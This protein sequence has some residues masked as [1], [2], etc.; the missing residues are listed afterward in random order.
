[1]EDLTSA[2]SQTCG[3]DLA[4]QR[5]SDAQLLSRFADGD[6]RAARTLTDRLGPR[7]YSVAMRILGNRAEAEDVTQE[8]MMRLWQIAPDW[9]A[10]QAQVSTWLYRVTLNLC[11]DLRR[12]RRPT[13]LE[14]APEPEDG[15][16]SVAEQM[17]DMARRDALQQALDQLPERQRQAVVL[18]HIEELSNPEIAEIMDISVEAVESLTARGKRSLTAILAGRKDELGYENG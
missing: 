13:T 16:A 4:A 2:T 9:V 17:L 1:M 6:A 10:G 8:A 11:V 3:E 12:R 18:R 5:L 15:A 14:D 7:S